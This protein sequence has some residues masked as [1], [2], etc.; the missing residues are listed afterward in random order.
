M[1]APPQEEIRDGT[2][3]AGPVCAPVT[4][5]T[6]RKSA[7][8]DDSESGAER[9]VA[10]ACD[11]TRHAGLGLQHRRVQIRFLSHL[12]S[13]TLNLCGLLAW[14]LSKVCVH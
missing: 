14:S 9:P 3:E 2:A 8:S 11:T 12:P 4:A 1:D 13:R 6:R 5:D 7:A 10:M